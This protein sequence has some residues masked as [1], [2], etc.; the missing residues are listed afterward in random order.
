MRATDEYK[1]LTRLG[2]VS[3]FRIEIL[4]CDELKVKDLTKKTKDKRLYIYNTEKR[5]AL[6]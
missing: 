5:F 6:C 3:F 2:V 1:L 4:P